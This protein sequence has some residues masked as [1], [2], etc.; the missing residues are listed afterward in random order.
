MQI[1]TINFNTHNCNLC[2]STSSL[3]PPQN[4]IMH[5]VLDIIHATDSVSKHIADA[6]ADDNGPQLSPKEKAE[7]IIA[8]NRVSD[9][10]NQI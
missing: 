10:P 4:F 5:T 9:A 2:P 6:Q 3:P 1:T 8:K 7:A